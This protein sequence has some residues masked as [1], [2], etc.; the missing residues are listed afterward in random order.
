MVV[1]DILSS[2]PGIPIYIRGDANVNPKH[3]TRPGVL[4]EFMDRYGL[5]AL[6]LGHTTYH[7]FTGDGTSNRQLDVLISS[8]GHSD[9]L[10]EIKCKKENPLVTSSHD[11]IISRFKLS[12]KIH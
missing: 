12:P 6:P 1:E 4:H 3:P 7:H 10:V 5:C 2:Y 11:L 8:I 9:K